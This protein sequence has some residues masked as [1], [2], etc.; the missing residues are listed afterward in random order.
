VLDVHFDMKQ[1]LRGTGPSFRYLGRPVAI[2]LENVRLSIGYRKVLRPTARYGELSS[3][4]GRVL[5]TRSTMVLSENTALPRRGYGAQM[6]TAFETGE[7]DR[8][9]WRTTGHTGQV[10][11]QVYGVITP[12]SCSK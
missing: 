2:S 6:E 5:Y 12:P 4:H 3:R 9:R 8:R 10:R 7:I 1:A 11:G